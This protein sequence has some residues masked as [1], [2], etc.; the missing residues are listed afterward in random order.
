MEDKRKVLLDSSAYSYFA[1]GQEPELWTRMRST[2]KCVFYGFDVIR[3]EL[4]NTPKWI[5]VGK[6]RF[7][8]TLLEYYDSIGKNYSFRNNF[9]IESLAREYMLHYRGGKP[10]QSLL[11]DFLIVA[12]ASFHGMD[13]VVSEDRS[14]MVA[15]SALRAYREVNRKT[16]RLSMPK[17]IAAN[18]VAELLD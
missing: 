6:K 9:M 5:V 13:I 7:R 2:E 10:A 11:N 14:T 18:E 12:C 16:P 4:A 8:D 15:K 17:F 3:R 1:A